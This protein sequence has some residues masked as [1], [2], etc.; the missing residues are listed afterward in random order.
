MRSSSSWMCS[1]RLR[2]ARS[3]RVRFRSSRRF[4]H[5]AA[6]FLLRRVQE[7][8]GVRVGYVGQ[9]FGLG[10][11]ATGVLGR[12]RF[13]RGA[14]L[15]GLGVRRLLLA[16]QDP[17]GLADQLGRTFLCLRDDFLGC[18]VRGPEDLGR[19]DANCPGESRLVELGFLGPAFGLDDTQPQHRLAFQRF[20]D[21]RGYLAEEDAH[22]L[23]VDAPARGGERLARDL[24]RAERR[25]RRD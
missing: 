15:E 14:D 19:L 5:H 6:A 3:A 2:D 1:A 20:A 22:C 23:A 21:L 16:R 25:A 13:G 12:L 18:V 11:S 7:L 10:P 9:R 24:V 8:D 17:V 4:G